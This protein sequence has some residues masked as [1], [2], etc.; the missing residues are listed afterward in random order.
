MIFI[1]SKISLAVVAIASVQDAG[2]IG[3][4]SAQTQMAQANTP[5]K[6]G[7]SLVC[8]AQYCDDNLDHCQL[9]WKKNK[10]Y[11]PKYIC[12]EK[13]S[14]IQI[15][16]G[17]FSELKEQYGDAEF[18]KEGGSKIKFP[19]WW[20]SWTHS[21]FRKR[22]DPTE[23]VQSRV[24]YLQDF[25][26]ARLQHFKENKYCVADEICR[27]FQEA[28]KLQGQMN[29]QTNVSGVARSVITHAT[30]AQTR[31]AKDEAFRGYQQKHVGDKL[32]KAEKFGHFGTKRITPNL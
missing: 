27:D 26:R 8:S 1:S 16:E 11:I 2:A 12:E 4:R 28:L 13:E 32:D 21:W 14:R 10:Y 18:D 19:H 20:G 24:N 15:F 23:Y 6:F 17:R 7:D 30:A 31:A 22:W 29:C 5:N 25:F 9:V 3:I